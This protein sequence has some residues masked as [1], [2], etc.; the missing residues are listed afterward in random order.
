[1]KF[2]LL[3]ER[4]RRRDGRIGSERSVDHQ[5]RLDVQ[6]GKEEQARHSKPSRLIARRVVLT[7]PRWICDSLWRKHAKLGPG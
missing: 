6:E 4:V 1:M 3:G 5:V 2:V 7:P